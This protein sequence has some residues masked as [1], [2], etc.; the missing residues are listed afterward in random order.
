MSNLTPQVYFRA[1]H[2]TQD[3]FQTCAAHFPTVP[4]RTQLTP[5]QSAPVICRMSALP[6]YRELEQDLHQFGLRPINAYS[7]HSYI[8]DMGWLFDIPHL[9]FPTW[10]RL[11]DAPIHLS[12]VI[13]GK[14]NSRKFEWN[15]RMFA[16][17][18]ADAVRIMSDL[19][20]DPL[21]GPQGLVFR[22]YVPL[23]TF[24]IGVNEMPMTNEWRCF[25][26]K[27]TLVDFGFYWS[28]MDNL[29]VVNAEDFS[30]NGLP[31]AQEAAN[32]V[33][34]FTNF[35]VLD[36]AKDTTGRW[37]V[38]EVNDGQMSGLSTIPMER[39]YP[40]LKRV[41]TSQG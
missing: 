35:F 38:V 39:F 7:Q 13:K 41:L 16:P 36:L 33:N 22:Q 12:L 15:T 30:Q 37:W 31:I 40:N 27:N 10:Q 20:H 6:F 29:D 23:K 14:T 24:E 32:L 26:Y 28:I 19:S 1:N 34:E 9:T 8:A 25:F 11:K 4:L 18:R 5:H 21:I 3:E 2:E 17:T